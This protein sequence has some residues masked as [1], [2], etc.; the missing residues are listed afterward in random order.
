MDTKEHRRRREVAVCT[1]VHLNSSLLARAMPVSAQRGA[2]ST[3]Y[4]MALSFRTARIRPSDEPTV[5]GITCI[6]SLQRVNRRLLA[7][8]FSI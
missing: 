6:R 4:E 5:A 1:S 7:T 3:R 8:G 2:A